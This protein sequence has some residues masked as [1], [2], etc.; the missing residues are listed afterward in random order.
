M[1]IMT[2]VTDVMTVLD[3]FFMDSPLDRPLDYPRILFWFYRR[4]ARVLGN[5]YCSRRALRSASVSSDPMLLITLWKAE[6]P[7]RPCLLARAPIF[8]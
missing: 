2:A 5:S 7:G 4:V 3:A 8:D 6:G 1:K